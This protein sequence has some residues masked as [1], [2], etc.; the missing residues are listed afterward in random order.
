MEGDKQGRKDCPS[1]EITSH[2]DSADKFLV[3]G[4]RRLTTIE[5]NT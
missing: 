4:R 1:S 3:I 5:P 2:I